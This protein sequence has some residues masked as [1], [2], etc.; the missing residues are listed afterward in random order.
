VRCLADSGLFKGGLGDFLGK[1][2]AISTKDPLRDK[3][4]ISDLITGNNDWMIYPEGS[5]IKNKEIYFK[6][7]LIFHTPDGLSRTKT[8]STVLAL[9]SELYRQE[10]IQAH[11]E[12]DIKTLEL[13]KKKYEID[14]SQDLLSVDTHIVPVNITY[15]PIRPGKNIINKFADKFLKR[16]PKKIAEELEIEGNLLLSANINI[17]FGKAIR[18]ANYSRRARNVVHKIPFI[19]NQAKSDLVIKYL[20]YKL[21]SKFMKD[22]Y[23][24]TKINLDHIFTATIYQYNKDKI[25]IDCLKNIIYLSAIE[26]K[27]SKK[28]RISFSIDDKNLYKIF[29]GEF[30]KNLDGIINLA[31]SL[32]IISKE[33]GKNFFIIDRNRINQEYDFD[34]I[35]K[36]NTLR[37][38]FNE[39]SINRSANLIVKN[40]IKLDENKLKY[41]VFKSLL[42]KDLDNFE[43]DYQKYFDKDLSKDKKIGTPVFLDN[44]DN[45]KK[46][47]GIILCH[48]YQSAP[49]EVEQMA[50]YL[51]KLGFKV[52]C[53]RLKGHGT[54][55]Q[56]IKDISYMD[57]YESFDLAYCAMN[58]ICSK[59][60]LI[61]FSTGG[62]IS[63]IACS[64]KPKKDIYALIVIN[65]ALKLQ[66]IRA[67]FIVPGVTIW[68]DLLNKFHIKK[69]KL[70]YVDNNS[71]NPS[72]NYSRNYLN[73]VK[74][75]GKLMDKCYDNLEKIQ[76]PAL[77]IYSKNDP[78][79]KPKGSKIIFKKIKSKTKKIVEIDID[80]HI[81]ICGK[82][83]AKVFDL[84]KKFILEICKA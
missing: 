6:G 15:Y 22:I 73:G 1:I 7:N 63:L 62:L 31:K 81:I 64:N 61:G 69:A 27:L 47:F 9:K 75:L 3:K 13:Y 28:Y 80:K 2:G 84:I 55:P 46:D 83:S 12:K 72:V 66:D 42:D 50:C 60:I 25:S 79:V 10:I 26:I 17:N 38:I 4:I 19:T 5:M 35:R 8:G 52:Y 20:K 21:T 70:E 39:F 48:G 32:K 57:W 41:K 53:V 71:E 23:F 18:V 43:N 30:N 45:T 34:Q 77:I 54:S 82:Q 59:I 14:F 51:N 68:N 49:K 36:E 33:F 76:N 37:V 58:R 44:K 24:D 65:S 67:R 40:N 16:L 11:N 29:N 78:V 74:E 56:N